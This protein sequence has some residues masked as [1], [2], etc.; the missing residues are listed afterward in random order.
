MIKSIIADELSTYDLKQYLSNRHYIIYFAAV[1]PKAFL[2]FIIKDIQT[3][4]ILLDALFKGRETNLSLNGYEIN[5]TELIHALECIGLDKRFLYEATYIL[6]YTMKYPKVGNYADSVKDLLGKIYQFGYP[7]TEATFAER[8]DV[9]VQLKKTNPIEVFW[10]LCHMIDSITKHHTFS[11][12]QGFPTHIN[13]R[14]K[15]YENTSGEDICKV[16]ALIPEVF[17]STSDDFL[18]CIKISMRHSLKKVITPLVE[19]LSKKS[20]N[21][22]R[23]TQLID[24]IEKEIMHHERYHDAEWALSDA[25]LLPFKAI[26]ETLCSNDLLLLNRKF[27][28]H[29][30][31][32]YTESYD[33]KKYAECK[34]ESNNIRGLKLQEIIDSLGIESVWT[35]AKTVENPQSVY[36]GLSI[37][38]NP[39]YHQ[40]V[41]TA[42]V[43][44]KIET[45]N[46]EIY[47]SQLYY[48]IG[49]TEY[50]NII[51]KLHLL[52]NSRIAVPIYA[53]CWTWN[54]AAKAKALGRDV[55]HHYWEKVRIWQ[56]P[57]DSHLEFVIQNL[58]DSQRE[59]DII[60]LITDEEIIEKINIELKIRVLKGAIFN[61]RTKYRQMD[62]YNFNKILLSVKDTEIHETKFE[63]DIL[64]IEGFLFQ[65]LNEY[66]NP[67]EELHIVRV[68]KWDPN[69]MIDLLK[70]YEQLNTNDSLVGFEILYRFVNDL[71]FVICKHEDGSIDYEH[72]VNYLSTLI[73]CN[74]LPMK[75]TLI[76]NLLYAIMITQE[77]P[78]KEFCNVIEILA[79]DDVDQ[80]LYLAISNSRGVTCRGCYDGG[81]QERNLAEHYKDLAK[82][83]FP[84]SFRL[85]KVFDN[86]ERSYIVEAKRMDEDA[87]RNKFR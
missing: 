69:M 28:L 72:V 9:L 67:G 39:D 58:L 40:E 46:A 27:F 51:D 13:R 20:E 77:E 42:L 57:E 75:Y 8:F 44:H 48:R 83:V 41:Y 25:E 11:I 53:P 64:E 6:F 38:N 65:T 84:Y 85:K 59:W 21:F 18:K 24:S 33:A 71:R 76:G 17:P 3:G 19:F 26:Y 50:L 79:N 82:K 62:F 4:G 34:L 61:A 43:A 78:S 52:D 10:V 87:L 73:K 86:L 49:E 70:S 23:D 74:E 31:P 15:E 55:N 60:S 1:N 80:H 81:Q 45:S 63:K 37:L 56:R 5:Y 7:Q 29:E 68:L 32:I 47:F 16:L 36:E 14:K 12:S 66:L 2:D 30:L 35:L 22:K 54:L